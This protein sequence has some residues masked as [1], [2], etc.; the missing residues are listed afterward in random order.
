M[1]TTVIGSYPKPEYITLT[2]WF[3]TSTMGQ[4]ANLTTDYLKNQ[5]SKDLEEKFMEA[6]D[7]VINE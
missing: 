5:G 3:K 1:R 7:E 2:D 6:I 4:Y